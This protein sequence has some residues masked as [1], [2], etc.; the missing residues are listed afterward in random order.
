M[1]KM[2]EKTLFLSVCSRVARSDRDLEELI[3]LGEGFV[4]V[5]QDRFFNFIKCYQR[6]DLKCSYILTE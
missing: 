4:V 5:G 2:L 3:G 1:G 6:I